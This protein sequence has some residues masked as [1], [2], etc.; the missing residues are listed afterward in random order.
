[1]LLETNVQKDEN[2]ILSMSK[3]YDTDKCNIYIIRI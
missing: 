2:E 1:M 3:Q